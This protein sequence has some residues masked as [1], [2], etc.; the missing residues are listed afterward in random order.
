LVVGEAVVTILLLLQILVGLAEVVQATQLQEQQLHLA[1]VL[2]AAM[3]V[4]PMPQVAVVAVP[5]A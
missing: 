1:K 5:A 3:V 2:Q 4:V